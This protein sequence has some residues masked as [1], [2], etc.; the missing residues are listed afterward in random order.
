M[1]AVN[2]SSEIVEAV[3]QL[4]TKLDLLQQTKTKLTALNQS[5]KKIHDNQA[6]LRENIRSL[7]KVNAG[8]L[9]ER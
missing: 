6:R 8:T 4:K 2:L 3:K 9:L 7:E 5:I 1:D